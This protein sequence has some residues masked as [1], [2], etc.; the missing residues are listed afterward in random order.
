MN[1]HKIWYLIQHVVNSV[2][3]W[4]SLFHAFEYFLKYLS[5]WSTE[6]ITLNLTEKKIKFQSIFIKNSAKTKFQVQ[7][8]NASEIESSKKTQR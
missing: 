6:T 5:F 4:N 2:D 7:W 1:F 8:C 3:V